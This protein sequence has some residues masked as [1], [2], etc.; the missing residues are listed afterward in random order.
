[1]ERKG[2]LG[3]ILDPHMEEQTNLKPSFRYI[4][5]GKHLDID[6]GQGGMCQPTKV[7]AKWAR[8][9]C[10]RTRGAAAPWLAPSW[11]SFV[12]LTSVIF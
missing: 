6:V 9:G 2:V 12:G 10:S 11:P 3:N 4:E 1:M 7:E 5:P 8:W